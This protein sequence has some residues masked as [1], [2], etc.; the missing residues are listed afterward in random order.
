MVEKTDVKQEGSLGGSVCENQLEK[1]K[2]SVTMGRWTAA[3][4][5][6]SHAAGMLAR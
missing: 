4:T 5:Y 6:S 1:H 2:E 3:L